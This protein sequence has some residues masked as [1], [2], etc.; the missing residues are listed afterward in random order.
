MVQPCTQ[1]LLTRAVHVRAVKVLRPAR[2]ACSFLCLMLSACAHHRRD[3]AQA[4]IRYDLA[5]RNLMEHPQI[6][7]KE[8]EKA[9]RLDP[10]MHEAWH[11]RGVLFHY[12]FGRHDEALKSYKKALAL[13]PKYSEANTNLG[14]LYVDLKRYDDAIVQYKKAL[15]NVLY[16]VPYIAHGNLGWAYYKKGK[17]AEALDHLNAA[18]TINPQYCL[19]HFKLGQLYEKNKQHQEACVH[20]SHYRTHCPERAEAWQYDGMCHAKTGDTKTAQESFQKCIEKSAQDITQ[21]NT[22]KKL[23]N[24]FKR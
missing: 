21:Q 24:Q 10:H 23:L 3:R 14:N 19:G 17:L 12:S 4:E 8:V 6:A 9:L 22:C 20:F 1:F 5:V 7:F 2:L 18:V 11:V 13:H 16:R 15:N